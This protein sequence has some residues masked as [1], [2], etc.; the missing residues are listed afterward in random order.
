MS[1]AFIGDRAWLTARPKA[2]APLA[3]MAGVSTA[4]IAPSVDGAGEKVVRSRS[5]L[6]A[7]AVP[8]I[9]TTSAAAT[10]AVTTRRRRRPATS[11]APSTRASQPRDA[12][13]PVV[14]PPPPRTSTSIASTVIGTVA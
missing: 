6:W 14:Q 8:A 7:L 10:T 3:P 1:P 12:W 9:A 5:R 2:Q 4:N 11:I 13:P